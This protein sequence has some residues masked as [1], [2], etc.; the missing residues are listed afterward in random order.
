MA[1]QT[2]ED[3]DRLGK[4]LDEVLADAEPPEALPPKEKTSKRVDIKA[5]ISERGRPVFDDGRVKVKA[6]LDKR[7]AADAGESSLEARATANG[8]PLDLELKRQPAP[9]GTPPTAGES[10]SQT[11][12]KER[13][14]AILPADAAL[15]P[16][17]EPKSGSRPAEQGSGG[18]PVTAKSRS[19]PRRP[20]TAAVVRERT[21]PA[22]GVHREQVRAPRFSGR[23]REDS[24][25][26]AGEYGAEVDR[27][28]EY[29]ESGEPRPGREEQ[30][31]ERR[32]NRKRIGET[33]AEL[34]KSEAGRQARRM[35]GKAVGKAAKAAGRSA[36]AAIA[37]TAP[38]WAPILLAAILLLWFVIVMINFGNQ[39][40]TVD[41][42]GGGHKTVTLAES[43]G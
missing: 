7:P 28:A 12:A 9:A 3:R 1:Q 11:S 24:L 36:L 16:H 30:K 22:V 6:E 33:A 41:L 20:E 17:P 40:V 25:G 31:R 29:E 32:E 42:P 35:A 34:A 4:A 14:D 39:K 43:Y 21:D 19:R 26:R 15:P 37:E 5:D 23:T 10:T 27:L 38:V 18:S 8:E 13:T 2:N